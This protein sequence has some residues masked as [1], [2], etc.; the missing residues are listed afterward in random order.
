[1]VNNHSLVRP[2]INTTPDT[3]ITIRQD[4]ANAADVQSQAASEIIFVVPAFARAFFSL[5]YA[6]FEDQLTVSLPDVRPIPRSLPSPA[7]EDLDVLPKNI[8]KILARESRWLSGRKPMAIVLAPTGDVLL[9]ERGQ[10]SI[11]L[12]GV[13]H[14]RHP[15][16][17]HDPH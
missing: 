7:S 1:M 16:R 8:T 11:D 14:H 13:A 17:Q 15:V 3:G 10:D 2:K 6:D 4:R 9:E 5:S 12:A